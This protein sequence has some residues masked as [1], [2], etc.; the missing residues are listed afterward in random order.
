MSTSIASLPS[1][2][3]QPVSLVPESTSGLCNDVEGSASYKK[4]AN[5][6]AAPHP[7]KPYPIQ[8]VSEAILEPVEVLQTLG[9]AMLPPRHVRQNLASWHWALMRYG[10]LIQPAPVANTPLATSA[11]VGDYRFHHMTALSEAVGVG[12]ALSYAKHWLRAEI[13]QPVIIHDAID[14]DY[15]L[16]SGAQSLPG[17][18]AS[19]PLQLAPNAT[20]QPDYVIVAEDQ[21]QA[22]RLMVVECKG[23]SGSRA[24]A[25]RQLGSAMQQLAGI[26]FG[27]G[28]HGHVP[29][30]Q[31]AYAA[32]MSKQGAAIDL[33]GV[34]PPDDEGDPWIRPAIPARQQMGALRALDRTTRLPLPSV[35]AIGGRA[36]R[37][38]EDKTVAWVGAGDG[39]DGVDIRRLT[40]RESSFGDVVGAA[41][42]LS[43]PD[44]YTVEIFTG[45][46]AGVLEAVKDGDMDRSHAERIKLA[47]GLGGREGK[48]LRVRTVAFDANE[49]PERVASAIDDDGLVL[50]IKITPGHHESMPTAEVRSPLSER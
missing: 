13:R 1:T 8:N 38:L 17:S 26:Q 40:H 19:I 20:R 29:V 30:I 43:L 15:L 44:G 21:R 49:D 11:L 23:T 50:R 6:P 10:Y 14:L 34:D 16:G 9:V 46:L 42:T 28:S 36:L 7:K 37:R 33:Y 41:S 24:T 32:R 27:P 18:A 45:A 48:R 35:E 12:C 2:L 22:V 5:R 4:Q 47:A 25:V 31:H 3:S 39:A